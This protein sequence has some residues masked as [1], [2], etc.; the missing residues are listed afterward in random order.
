M[1]SS[2]TAFNKTNPRDVLLMVFS[3]LFVLGLNLPFL[4]VSDKNIYGAF[5]IPNNGMSFKN[6]YVEPRN[7]VE[8]SKLPFSLN[9][10]VNLVM[11][12]L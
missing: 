7:V 12:N 4:S 11:C 6:A 10:D 8:I 3:I 2:Y 9:L 5:K 1:Y